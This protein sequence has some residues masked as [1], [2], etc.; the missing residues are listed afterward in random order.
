VFSDWFCLNYSKGDQ[1]DKD[2]KSNNKTYSPLN[3]LLVKKAKNVEKA[4]AKSYLFISPKGRLVSVYNLSKFSRLNGLTQQSMSGVHL[5]KSKS[6]K[7]WRAAK[8][9]EPNQC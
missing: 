2:I 6:H 4:K 7:G 8:Q 3:C 1:L 5:G 9:S